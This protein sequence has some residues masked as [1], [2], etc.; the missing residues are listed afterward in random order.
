MCPCAGVAAPVGWYYE[1]VWQITSPS[2]NLKQIT[3]TA[4]VAT[5]VAKAII[6]KSTVSALKSSPF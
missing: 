1:R 4:T 6:P 2:V 5:S 3:V